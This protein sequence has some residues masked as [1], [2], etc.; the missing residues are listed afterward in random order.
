MGSG[1][2]P[3][4]IKNWICSPYA[5]YKYIFGLLVNILA[6]KLISRD[7]SHETIFKRRVHCLDSKQN[8]GGI[9][10]TNSNCDTGI[11]NWPTKSCQMTCPKFVCKRV[12]QLFL[13]RGLTTATSMFVTH[14]VLNTRCGHYSTFLR[15]CSSQRQSLP[16]PWD[17][18][19]PSPCVF[20][21]ALL[22]WYSEQQ[23]IFQKWDVK[24]KLNQNFNISSRLDIEGYKYGVH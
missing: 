17:F 2:E 8:F 11:F 24:R 23:P 9:S 12:G 13:L 5:H 15:F 22:K 14:P 19:W 4:K 18:S 6:N 10:N 7:M 21:S 3:K 1:L 20:L 16:L